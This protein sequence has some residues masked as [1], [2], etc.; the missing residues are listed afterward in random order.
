MSDEDKHIRYYPEA[1]KSLTYNKYV[2]FMNNR[3]QA[4]GILASTGDLN[5]PQKHA[6][7]GFIIP[8]LPANVTF[9][10][11]SPPGTHQCALPPNDLI[12]ST[13]TGYEEV[14][15]VIDEFDTE[16]IRVAQR[17]LAD[18]LAK[19]EPSAGKKHDTGK[20]PVAQGLFQYFPAALKAVALV[21]K[22][23]AQ[24]Y[25]LTYAERNWAKVEDAKKRY[26]DALARHVVDSQTPSGQYDE[27]SKLLHIAHAAWDAL[28]VLELTLQ[29]IP[30]AKGE[31]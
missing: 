5:P 18:H 4:T 17:D 21:S 7:Q 11:S 31:G 2:E 9:G 26:S 25:D 3:Y 27:E 13:D 6:D 20:A 30:L 16:L 22:Y 19:K 1:N 15:P 29:D 23:G 12:G 14:V 10:A 28:A 24:K 8:S